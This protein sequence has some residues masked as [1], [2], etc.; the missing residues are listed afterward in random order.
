MPLAVFAAASVEARQYGGGVQLLYHKLPCIIYCHQYNC[1]ELG[2]NNIKPDFKSGIKLANFNKQGTVQV[3]NLAAFDKQGIIYFLDRKLFGCFV[4]GL[5][6]KLDGWM[7]R[8]CWRLYCHGGQHGHN[9]RG[10]NHY[11]N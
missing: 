8:P 11:Q 4:K 10:L 1:H 6:V 5:V 9:H 7:L 3:P 2:H